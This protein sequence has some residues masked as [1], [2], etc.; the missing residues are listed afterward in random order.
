MCS[1]ATPQPPRQ[2]AAPPDPPEQTAEILRP[3]RARTRRKEKDVLSTL[4]IPLQIPQA[5]T[6]EAPQ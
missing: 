2:P 3:S 6:A 4:R 1:T 5:P